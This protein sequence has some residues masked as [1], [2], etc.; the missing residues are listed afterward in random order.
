MGRN[1]MESY[2]SM[3]MGKR[4]NTRKLA[5]L[6]KSCNNEEHNPPMFILLEPGIYENIQK[7]TV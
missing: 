6:P 5:D 3:F 7:F 1:P 2:L 4:I